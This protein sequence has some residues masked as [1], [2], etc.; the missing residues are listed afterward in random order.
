MAAAATERV[1]ILMPPD[2]KAQL[3]ELARHAG[4]SIG[5]FIRRAVREQVSDAEFE[6]ELER[7]RPDVEALLDA[8]E[9]SSTRA[10]AALDAALAS[11]EETRRQFARA[12][13]ERAAS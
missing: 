8:L 11:V 4:V 9:E 13:S 10:H 6:A 2:E 12:G 7:R 5:E 1:V 3:V